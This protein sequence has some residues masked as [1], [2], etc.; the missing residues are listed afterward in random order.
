M[1]ERKRES[2]QD[3]ALLKRLVPYIRNYRLLIVF[4]IVFM[5]GFNVAGVLQPYLFKLGIDNYVV[6]GDSQGLLQL[7]IILFIVMVSGFLLNYFFSLTVQYLGQR[8]LY[9]IR[10]HLFRHV[11][12]LDNRYF[13]THPVGRT[14][15]HITNDVEA[16]RQF[17]SEGVVLV[18]GGIIWI[19]IQ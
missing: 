11:T 10:T 19:C 6:K 3:W 16:L 15:T 4:S 17:I 8:L 18:M 7:S 12:L 9:D 1:S 14:L 13:D 5:V 2:G